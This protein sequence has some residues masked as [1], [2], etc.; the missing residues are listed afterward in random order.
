LRSQLEDTPAY[1]AVKNAGAVTHS[2]LTVTL[3][4]QWRQV[5][6]G[7][8]I[9]L[10]WSVAY[11]VCFAYLP[12]FAT[13]ELGFAAKD[14]FSSGSSPRRMAQAVHD[15]RGKTTQFLVHAAA[16]TRRC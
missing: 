13:N 12:T 15:A 8:G 10:L 4:T 6:Q 5:L 7:S 14:A 9:T 16:W 1:E 11:Y 3:R 2:P